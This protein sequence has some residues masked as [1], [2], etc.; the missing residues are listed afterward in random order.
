[1][2][3]GYTPEQIR[4]AF[5]QASPEEQQ[6]FLD[7][8][9]SL[10]N[11]P[12]F[13]KELPDLLKQLRSDALQNALKVRQYAFFVAVLVVVGI[14]GEKM[15]LPLLGVG[16]VGGVVLVTLDTGC[17]GRKPVKC[18]TGRLRTTCHVHFLVSLL[19]TDRSELSLFP[20]TGSRFANPHMCTTL[21]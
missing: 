8:I 1:M 15:E 14:F 21:S 19:Q 6:Q 10:K 11:V 7:A 17:K 16:L 18:Y 20:T 4:E 9:N 13:T 12:S 5:E 2:D 3:H